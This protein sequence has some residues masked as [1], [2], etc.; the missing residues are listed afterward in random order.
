MLALFTSP[1]AAII[2]ALNCSLS[3]FHL[4]LE[5]ALVTMAMPSLLAVPL[6]AFILFA[7]FAFPALVDHDRSLL[8]VDASELA[9]SMPDILALCDEN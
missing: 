4:G 9:P 3:T 1:L 7:A 2:A 5:L 6:L 8:M